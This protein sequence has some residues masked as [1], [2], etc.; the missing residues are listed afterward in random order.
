MRTMIS[1]ENFSVQQVI[2]FVQLIDSLH[3]DIFEKSTEVK[4]FRISNFQT[5]PLEEI[6]QDRTKGFPFVLHNF[7]FS[8]F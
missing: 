4:K 8:L 3:R 7:S 5:Y 1:I 6:N 2:F